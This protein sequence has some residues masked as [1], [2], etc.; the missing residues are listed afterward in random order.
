MVVTAAFQGPACWYTV[1]HFFS[2]L[3]VVRWTL[4]WRLLS[5]VAWAVCL[6]L[7]VRTPSGQSCPIRG[8]V[9]AAVGLVPVRTRAG[10]YRWPEDSKHCIPGPL[11]SAGSV[12]RVLT[13]RFCPVGLGQ[14]RWQLLQQEKS[15]HLRD[16]ATPF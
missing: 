10:T 4:R 15:P 6:C 3:A 14:G 16:S 11:C 12:F 7:A 1:C 9:L 13:N 8:C 2:V 5:L